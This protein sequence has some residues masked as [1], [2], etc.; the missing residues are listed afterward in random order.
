MA[1]VSGVSAV[2]TQPFGGK[3]YYYKKVLSYGPIAY[4]PLWE[5][6]GAVA[7]CLVNPAQNGT[8]SGVTLGQQGI[9][10]GRTCPYY[11]G[12][13]DHTN[14][15][16]VALDAAFNGAELSFVIWARVDAAAVWTDGIARL[17]IHF[18]VDADNRVYIGK[19]LVNNQLDFLYEAGN[20]LERV[21]YNIGAPT[22]WLSLGITASASAGV[23]GEVRAYVNGTQ[24]GATQTTLG[25]WAG[26]LDATRVCIGAFNTAPTLVWSGWLG[27]GAVFNRALAPAEMAALAVV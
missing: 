27:H 10:D 24:V 8:H 4:W 21:Q 16:S 3:T 6:S 18:R 7:Q 1:G 17:A 15:Y 26:A 19:D 13:N 12:A 11:D 2:Q 14:T 5:P 9:G 22:S 23:D 20:V 25:V